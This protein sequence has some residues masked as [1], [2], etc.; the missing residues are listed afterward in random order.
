[1]LAE[2]THDGF[3]MADQFTD[4]LWVSLAG[5]VHV[6]HWLD[7]STDWHSAQH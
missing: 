7:C 1:M 6:E 4:P 2:Y 5:G 3:A